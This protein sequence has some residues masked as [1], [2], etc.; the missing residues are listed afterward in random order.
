MNCFSMLN[1]LPLKSSAREE[2]GFSHKYFQSRGLLLQTYVRSETLTL[3]K[4]I[5][6]KKDHGFQSTF[7]TFSFLLCLT[8]THLYQCILVLLRRGTNVSLS[9]SGGKMY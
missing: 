8:L 4:D 6:A 2:N 7:W 3:K 9:P 5:A 1:F